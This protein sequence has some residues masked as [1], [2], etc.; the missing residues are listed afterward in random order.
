M[1]KSSELDKMAKTYIL[2]CVMDNT[3]HP[4]LG[5]NNTKIDHI[6]SRF[7]SE[8]A[9]EIK[10]DGELMALTSWLQGLGFPGNIAFYNIDILRLAKEWGSLPEHPTEAQENRILRNY[11]NFMT[12]KTLQLFHGYRIPK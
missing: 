11:W 4:Y 2:E 6:R 9:W 8:K 3:G 5:N 12:N 10:Q 7:E 1:S